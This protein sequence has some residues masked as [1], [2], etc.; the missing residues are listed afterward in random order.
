MFTATVEYTDEAAASVVVREEAE[1]AVKASVLGPS[2]WAA[3]V[4]NVASIGMVTVK[5]SSSG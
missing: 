4:D 5:E 3:S 1:L 2:V